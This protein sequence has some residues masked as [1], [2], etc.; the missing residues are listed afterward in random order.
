MDKATKINSDIFFRLWDVFLSEKT[1]NLRGEYFS[2]WDMWYLNQ[3]IIEKNI[4]VD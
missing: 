4:I 2:F 1:I 3:N